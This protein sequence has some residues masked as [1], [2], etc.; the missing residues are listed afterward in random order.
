MLTAAT[1]ITGAIRL[2]LV[3]AHATSHGDTVSSRG[4]RTPIARAAAATATTASATGDP[5]G[6]SGTG[7]AL[8]AAATLWGSETRFGVPLDSQAAM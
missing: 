6:A 8:T 2:A 3:T 1:V 4:Q 5:A 7:S